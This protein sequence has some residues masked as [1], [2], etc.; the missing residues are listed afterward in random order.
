MKNKNGFISTAVVYSFLI[1]FL[2]IMLAILNSYS[3]K[4]K[5]LEAINDKIEINIGAKE[6]GKST[7][8]NK[9]LSDNITLSTNSINYS[10]IANSTNG[11][12]LFYEDIS[13][14]KRIYFYRGE[15]SNNYVLFGREFSE[16]DENTIGNKIC[17]KIL[18]T[19]LDG[20]IRL[21]YSGML[22]DNGFCTSSKTYIGMSKYN[23]N[24]NDNAYV[25][26]TYGGASKDNY[27]LTH[28]YDEDK[29]IIESEIKK[30]L[31]NWYKYNTDLS[32]YTNIIYSEDLSDK[33]SVKDAYI[34]DTI[35]CADRSV[36]DITT[37][38]YGVISTIYGSRLRINLNQKP[39][40][41]CSSIDDEYSLSVIVGGANSNPNSIST[42]VGLLSVDEVR[43]A[44]G[45][46]NKS[47]NKYFLYNSVNYWTMS[48]DSYENSAKVFNV[49]STGAIMSSNVDQEYAIRPVIS[50]KSDALI[51][52]GTGYMEDPY[53]VY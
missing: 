26:Y 32:S 35:F 19:N 46:Y 30:E 13:S 33:I 45:A 49:S 12:G 16:D 3:D 50:I 22:D 48:P 9:M 41:S 21:V 6:E 53:I 43:Y 47:N 8:L 5:F 10:N 1:I 14:D 25:G 18:H 20:S 34:A 39:Q 7:L 36:E 11:R 52:R 27:E 2:F 51:D 17:W 24:K 28:Y 44:G 40:F 23:N 4:N 15:V 29:N 37:S 42:P 38:G 31:E